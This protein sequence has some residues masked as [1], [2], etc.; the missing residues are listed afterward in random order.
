ME[1]ASENHLL[2]HWMIHRKEFPGLSV[3]RYAISAQETVLIGRAFTY[4]DE[5]TRLPRIGYFHRDT[6]RFTVADLDGKIHTHFHTEE[7]YL[8]GLINN[9]YTDE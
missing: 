7:A 5:R 6:A 8:F 4:I 3:D 9:T 1:W 2:E